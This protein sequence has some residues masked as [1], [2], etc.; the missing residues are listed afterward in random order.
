ML[1]LRLLQ[2]SLMLPHELAA[3]TQGGIGG[4]FLLRIE[5][6]SCEVHRAN[7]VTHRIIGIHC[8]KLQ[9]L[10]KQVEVWYYM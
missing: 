6:I 7:T 3:C 10:K 9:S 5:L 1:G 8:M 2:T 4:L